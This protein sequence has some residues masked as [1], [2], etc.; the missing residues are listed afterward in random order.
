MHD[1]S[2]KNHPS[3]KSVEFEEGAFG[4]YSSLTRSYIGRDTK[5]TRKFNNEIEES[6]RM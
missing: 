2:Y 3:L 5:V 6:E 4:G 1:S